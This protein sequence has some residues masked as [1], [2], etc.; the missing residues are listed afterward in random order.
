M[1]LKLFILLILICSL[2][3][4]SAQKPPA[5]NKPLTNIN[6]LVCKSNGVSFP[7][8]DEYKV[9]LNNDPSNIFLA[10]NTRFGYSVFVIVPKTT[11]EEQKFIDEAK[12]TLLKT[13][14]PADSLDYR[15][16][17]VDF[18]DS[19]SSSKFE[20]GKNLSLGFNGEQ[21]VTVEY[22]RISFKNKN[23][24]IGTIVK[25]RFSGI[26]AEEAFNQSRHTTN[27]G[28]VDAQIIIQSITGENNSNKEL[29]FCGKPQ[30]IFRKAN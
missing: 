1:N 10:Q 19:S 7:C 3:L 29:N 5:K 24:F 9:V 8:P 2:G 18:E 15:W 28:C 23:L 12:K 25:D 17:N 30:V 20:V 11:V 26:Y 16:K 27:G 13:L 22:R 4:V 21:T 6:S 14:Y